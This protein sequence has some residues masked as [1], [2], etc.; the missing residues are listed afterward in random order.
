MV[1]EYD[2][3]CRRIDRRIGF[4]LTLH[5]QDFGLNDLGP[6][7]RTMGQIHRGADSWQ[8][9]MCIG[10]PT[11]ARRQKD[12]QRE[13]AHEGE[14]RKRKKKEGKQTEKPKIAQNP[15]TNITQTDIQF[16]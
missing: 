11:V 16:Q 13:E 8:Q 12:T 6:V 3:Y 2:K 9:Y 4:H 14:G 1:S 7:P 15:I 5:T 10:L